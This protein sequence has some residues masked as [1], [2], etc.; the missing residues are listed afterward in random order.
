M[1]N[2]IKMGKCYNCSEEVLSD[3]SEEVL[4]VSDPSFCLCANCSNNDEIWN[5][6]WGKFYPYGDKSIWETPDQDVKCWVCRRKMCVTFG[7]EVF[8]FCKLTSGCCRDLDRKFPAIQYCGECSDK[9]PP[10]YNRCVDH[11]REDFEKAYG[12]ERTVRIINELSKGKVTKG[13]SIFPKVEKV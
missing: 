8:S 2:V 13:F 12:K 9:L 4:S 5:E 10:Q 11:D 1:N 3:C 6:I 7:K